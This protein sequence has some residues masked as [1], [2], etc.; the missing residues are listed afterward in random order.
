MTSKD[1]MD[2]VLGMDILKTVTYLQLN[3]SQELDF[4]SNND[5]L[6]SYVNNFI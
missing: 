6:K 4:F 1:I 3:D 2:N 5:E